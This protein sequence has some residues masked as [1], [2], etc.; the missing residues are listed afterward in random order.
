ME[1][2]AENLSHLG[3]KV[4]GN[5]IVRIFDE[6]YIGP[7]DF[8]RTGKIFLRHL[9]GRPQGTHILRYES[10]GFARHADHRKADSP[11]SP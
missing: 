1:R 11:P 5:G 2:D 7:I 3:E 10:P 9:L 6:A 4:N 8:S